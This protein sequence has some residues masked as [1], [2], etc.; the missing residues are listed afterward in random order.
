MKSDKA[1]CFYS[2]GKRFEQPQEKLLAGLHAEAL[3]TLFIG[4][5]AFITHRC[6]AGYTNHCVLRQAAPLLEQAEL[7]LAAPPWWNPACG[8]RLGVRLVLK[9]QQAAPSSSKL[10]T[11]NALVSY[12][13]QLSLGDTALTC[14]FEAIAVEDALGANP[15]PVG[16]AGYRTGGSCHAVSGAA[17]TE[18]RDEPSSGSTTGTG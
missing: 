17:A 10:L 2:V 18:R 9:P 3:P 11:L 8:S 5:S 15:R 16:A 13:W 4:K 12:E 1:K 7:W 6:G 14:E